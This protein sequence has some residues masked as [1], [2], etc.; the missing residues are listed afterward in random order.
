MKKILS[1][2]AFCLLS[3]GV[4]VAQTDEAAPSPKVY[5]EYG[6]D[7][8][9]INRLLPLE[10]TIGVSSPY[11]F[12]MKRWN[13]AGKVERFG[14]NIN[15]VGQSDTRDNDPSQ[16]TNSIDIDYRFGWGKKRNAFKKA[17]WYLGTDILVN[18]LFESTKTITD[19][20]G[21]ETENKSTTIGF[22]TG[23]GPWV[24]LQYN[25]TERIGL[26]TEFAAYLTF[27]YTFSEFQTDNS[28]LNGFKEKTFS[29]RSKFIIPGNLV[30]FFKI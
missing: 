20:S 2:L 23:I 30:I 1:V 11:L 29:Y 15:I 22:G 26:Y 13:D 5:K 24:G 6:I 14:L 7:A 25:F 19:F 10:R 27:D 8:L 28:N 12:N 16:V 17:D 3:L 4:I 21:V 18:P 9:F